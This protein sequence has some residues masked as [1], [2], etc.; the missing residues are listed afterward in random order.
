[1]FVPVCMV[2]MFQDFQRVMAKS[3]DSSKLYVYY[4]FFLYIHECVVG[5]LFIL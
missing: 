2:D 5:Q 4:I 3:A 1:M